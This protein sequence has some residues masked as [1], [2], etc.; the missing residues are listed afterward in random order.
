MLVDLATH[1]ASLA[2]NALEDAPQ[3]LARPAR[4]FVPDAALVN[5]YREGDT[6]GGHQDDVEADMQQPIVSISLGCSAV[7]LIGGASRDVVPMPLLLRGGDVVVMTGPARACFHGV[8]RV[9]DGSWDGCEGVDDRLCTRCGGLASSRVSTTSP[10]HSPS[11]DAVGE[12]L[13][14]ARINI[15]IRATT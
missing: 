3:P 2:Y 10:G 7:F 4:P 1:F 11:R 15:S 9:V 6:L 5:Y 13:R 14:H 12:Y 8:P